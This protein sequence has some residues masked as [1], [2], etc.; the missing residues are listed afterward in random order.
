ML[1]G[2][3]IIDYLRT[4]RIHINTSFGNFAG[5]FNVEAGGRAHT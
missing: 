3:V 4:V 5:F 2:E 1:L